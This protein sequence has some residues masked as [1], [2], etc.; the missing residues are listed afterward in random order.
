[1]SEEYSKGEIE[2]VSIDSVHMNK[3]WSLLAVEIEM[4]AGDNKIMV[5]YKIGTGS[6]GNIML[7]HIFKRLFPSVT[8]AKLKK[9]IKRHIK[10]KAYNKIVIAQLGTCAVTINFKDNKKRCDFF[11]VAGNGQA[12]LGMPDTI[13]LKIIN[14]NIDSIQTV[15]EECNPN[16]GDAKESNTKQGSACGRGELQK[17]GCRYKN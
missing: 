15:K 10:L 8:E 14:K 1:M 3:N 7:W 2:T 16:I 17:Q 6:K 13:P 11:V 12:L 9:T 4:H 5:P